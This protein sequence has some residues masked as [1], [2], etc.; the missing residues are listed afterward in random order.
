MLFVPS[1][2]DEYFM[3]EEAVLPSTQ[4]RYFTGIL[5]TVKMDRTQSSHRP[6]LKIRR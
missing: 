5:P 4:S 1:V 2:Q 3:R 6:P